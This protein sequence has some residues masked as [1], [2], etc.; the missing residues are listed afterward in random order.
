M[1]VKE[2]FEMIFDY[3]ESPLVNNEY[4]LA[5]DIIVP[6][7]RGMNKVEAEKVLA[8]NGLKTKITGKGDSIISM[9]PYP[10]TTIK[11]G[12]EVEL[13][14]KGNNIDKKVVVP[15]LK[16]KTVENAK[17]LLENLGLTCT[18]EGEGYVYYQSTPKGT[19]VDKGTSIKLTLKKESEY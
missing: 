8:E 4:S 3:I 2:L 7:V 6:D 18:S 13:S 14:T 11:E 16:G 15:D 12:A 19:V 9:D 1:K 17:A 5:R 10:G